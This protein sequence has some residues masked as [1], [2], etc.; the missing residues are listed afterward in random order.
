MTDEGTTEHDEATKREGAGASAPRT[1]KREG[2]ERGT[3]VGRYVILDVLGQG[4]MGI[5]YSAYDPELDRKV[6]I[7]LLQANRD[8]SNSGGQAYLV[9]EAQ[10]MARLQH[11]NVI[12]VHDV[13]TLPGDRLFVAMELVDGLTLRAWFK[14]EKRPWREVVRVM[15]AAGVG[16]AEAHKVGLVHRDFKPDNVLVGNDGR[17][18]VMDFG[19]ARMAIDGSAAAPAPSSD[20]Q[21]EARSPLSESLTLAGTVL[22]TP[23][24][25]APEIYDGLGAGPRS[26]QFAFGVALYEGLYQQRP[27]EKGALIAPRATVPEPRP[28]P[29]V[30]VP[31][32]IHRAVLRA[33]AIDPEARFPSMDALLEELV[34]EPPATRKLA[35]AGLGVLAVGGLAVAGFAMTRSHDELCKGT[36]RRL[37]GVWD[38]KARDAVHTAFLATKLPYAEQAFGGLALDLDRHTS[39]WVAAVTG[40]CVAT[41]IRGDQSDE[42]LTL[43]QSCFDQ[44]LEELRALE[45]IL[46]TADRSLVDNADK[47]VRGLE[48]LDRCSDVEALRAPHQPPPELKSKYDELVKKI[49]V[50]KAQVVGGQLALALSATTAVIESAKLIH[51]E[52]LEAEALLVRGGALETANNIP[53][54]LAALEQAAWTG[55]R[56]RRDDVVAQASLTAAATTADSL[57]NADQAKIWLEFGIAASAR[58]GMDHVLELFRLET[59]GIVD[60]QHGEMVAAIAAHEKALATAKESLGVD[61]P[62]LWHF[63][64]LVGATMSKGGAWIAAAPHYEH[65][66]KLR[67]TTVGA[68]HADIA[69]ILSNLGTCYLRAGKPDAARDVFMRALA[70]REQ[71]FGP[72]SPMLIATL[73]NLADFKVTIADLP[74]ALIDIERARAIAEKVPGPNHPLFHTIL[75]TRGEVLAAA[76]RIAEARTQLDEVLALETKTH[77]PVEPTT[78]ASRGAIELADHRWTDAITFDERAIAAFEASGGKEQLELWKPLAGL[79]DA[80]RALDAKADVRALYERALAIGT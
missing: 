26:D 56:S 21:I 59:E 70:I 55:L 68:T 13:G 6:A 64:E 36:E 42:V 43:R 48:S 35:F 80:K 5:V 38:A 7:K 18:R 1:P 47:V 50:A 77:S 15:R 53:D 11:P 27:F 67:S 45:L 58:V 39:K 37:D 16:L 51:A 20:L 24:Y 75:T 40:S 74:G 76:G 63:E 73:N 25:M 17:V 41:R 12:A 66:L 49:A 69:L 61:N 71:L 60:A 52:D 10:A 78:L 23:A 30:G 28:A 2:L 54:G 33:I 44:R 14:A 3:L 31:A 22:G 79:A 9:R 32:K 62:A 4:G 29:D 57:G 46:T 72:S 65:A 8:G 19:L 34:I